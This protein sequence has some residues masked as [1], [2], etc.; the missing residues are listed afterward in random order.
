MP[1]TGNGATQRP[2]NT[3]P[4]PKPNGTFP[5]DADLFRQAPPCTVI[6]IQSGRAPLAATGSLDPITTSERVPGSAHRFYPTYTKFLTNQQRVNL[7]P[8]IL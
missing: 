1:T 8:R 5:P 4:V 3:S 6:R 7:N 2:L